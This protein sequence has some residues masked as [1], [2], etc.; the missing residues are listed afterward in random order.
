MA[1]KQPMR[2]QCVMYHFQV[3][4]SNFMV[5]PVIWIFSRGVGIL[6]DHW[7]TISCSYCFYCCCCCLCCYYYSHQCQYNHHHHHVIKWRI[8]WVPQILLD[9]KARSTNTVKNR[10][11]PKTI[12]KA[13]FPDIRGSDVF[14]STLSVHML[15]LAQTYLTVSFSLF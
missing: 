7:F 5:T 10:F 3:N 1:Q 11:L 4:R 14:G 6:I 8:D 15:A 13:E 2:G 9:W 12:W